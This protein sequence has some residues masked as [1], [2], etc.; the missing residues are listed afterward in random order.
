MAGEVIGYRRSF[1]QGPILEADKCAEQC[2]ETKKRREQ[3]VET[4]DVLMQLLDADECADQ[5]W[6]LNVGMNPLSVILS[7]RFV[8]ALEL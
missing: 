8:P 2:A 3:I 6:R 1:P 7:G 5:I 4:V